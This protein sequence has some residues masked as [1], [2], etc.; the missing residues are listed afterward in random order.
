MDTTST[1]PPAI[2]FEVFGSAS[3][4]QSVGQY[5]LLLEH[6]PVFTTPNGHRVISRWED[7]RQIVNQPEL[8]SNRPNQS[9]GWSIPTEDATEDTKA[10]LADVTR[11]LN[12]PVSLEDLMSVRMI[13]AADPPKHGQLRGLVNRA[14]VPRQMERWRPVVDGLVAE[15]LRT[16]DGRAP[17][18]LI[19]TLAAPLPIN[20]ISDVL[21]IKHEDRHLV[22]RWSD[23]MIGAAEGP[24]RGTRKGLERLWGMFSEFADY[25]FPIIEARRASPRDDMV[26]NIVRDRDD[27]TLSDADAL[28]LILILM[29]GGNETTTNLIGN[30][31]VSLLENPEQLELFLSQ[32]ELV[33]NVV[34]E[35]LRYRSPVQYEFREATQDTELH[36]VEI[37]TGALVVPML[38]AAN[39][40]PRVFDEPDRFDIRRANANLNVAFGYGIHFCVGAPLARLEARAA[41]VALAPLLERMKLAAEAP[42]PV[43]SLM[44]YGY[45]RLELVPR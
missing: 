15:L 42:T 39:H 44:L 14:F 6:A 32:P 11:D 34:E 8:F 18:E 21:S 20:V 24:E 7:V 22:R 35:T 38:G 27:A 23:G 45:S 16:I 5:P 40:D 25:F 19:D 10:L 2:D 43:E 1:E 33:D 13:I 31:V 30:A 37:P 9:E 26:S 17:T 41:L 28:F 3:A 4:M 29:A 36:G 12:L